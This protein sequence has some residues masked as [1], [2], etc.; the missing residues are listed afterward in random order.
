MKYSAYKPVGFYVQVKMEKFENKTASGIILAT[1]EEEKREQAGQCIGKIV[2]F[3]P[4][5]YKG[6]A[7]CDGPDDW[8]VKVGDRFET[9]RYAGSSVMAEGYA[10]YRLLSD[11]E[12]KATIRS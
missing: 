3:G 8:G 12:I 10:D 4:T 9:T 7:G 1:P 6:F 2:E 5:A 11:S